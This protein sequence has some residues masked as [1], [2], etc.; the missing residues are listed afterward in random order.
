[1][2][3]SGVVSITLKEKTAEKLIRLAVKAGLTGIEWSENYHINAGDLSAAAR[4]R[5]ETES[6]G[7]EV[8]S[9]GSYFRLGTEE[10]FGEVFKKTLSTAR[11]LGTPAMRVWAGNKSS[12]DVSGEEFK[13][14]VRESVVIADIAAVSPGRRRSRLERI[15][16]A[17]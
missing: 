9:Y 14:I 6:A 15:F 16:Q 11:E 1:M 3:R 17:D 8:V 5:T 13:R 2:L 12:V 4:L 7:L 10:N